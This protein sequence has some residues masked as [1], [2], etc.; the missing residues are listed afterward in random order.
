MTVDLFAGGSMMQLTE[1]ELQ[2]LMMLVQQY[3]SGLVSER[4]LAQ[5]AKAIGAQTATVTVPEDWT[6][7]KPEFF[8][9][10]MEDA[11]YDEGIPAQV[12]WPF[13]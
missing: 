5:F 4:D 3:K 11:F 8:I 10:D 7:T 6:W 2:R 1:A 9:A 13:G 12:Q